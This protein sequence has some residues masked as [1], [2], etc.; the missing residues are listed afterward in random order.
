MQVFSDA[1]LVSAF[2]FESNCGFASPCASHTFMP[3]W[4]NLAGIHVED[5]H[6]QQGSL[7]QQ[8]LPMW[9]SRGRLH[10]GLLVVGNHDTFPFNVHADGHKSHTAT[11]YLI[12]VG[13]PV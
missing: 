10:P 2:S 7:T 12:D 6:L 1:R 13:D 8:R 3:F 5:E 9:L 4:Y 11:K